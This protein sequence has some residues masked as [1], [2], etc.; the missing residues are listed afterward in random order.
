MPSI[1]RPKPNSSSVSGANAI[2]GIER[3]DFETRPRDEFGER[4]KAEENS[5]QHADDERDA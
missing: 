3:S 4:G 2:E 1:G 5:H